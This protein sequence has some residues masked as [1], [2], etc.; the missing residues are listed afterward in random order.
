MAK[1]WKSELKDIVSS[2]QK[3]IKTVIDDR[4]KRETERLKKIDEI[5]K[6]IKPRFEYVRELIEKDKYLL[7]TF[8]QES[9]AEATTERSKIEPQLG[10]IT[11][12][13]EMDEQTRFI[14]EAKHG[15]QVKSPT[16]KEG[17][18]EIVL[19]M[20]SLSDINRL[21]LLYQIEFKDEKPVLHAFDLLPA[22]KMQNNG[23]A[24]SDFEDFIQK[25]TDMELKDAAS[26]LNSSS[27]STF[28]GVLKSRLAIRWVP[29]FRDSKGLRFF[30]I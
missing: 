14:E 5:K 8:E 17:P 6:I 11:P 12:K 28:T 29:S 22:G 10:T 25:M 20:P 15:L 19:F 2:Q 13:S 23:S 16:V 24:H 7:S 21:D 26:S 9:K 1:D 30:R 4:E 18:A 3:N 27:L